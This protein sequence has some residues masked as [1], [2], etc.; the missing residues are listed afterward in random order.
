MRKVAISGNGVTYEGNR[1]C[2][3]TRTCTD[4]CIA[5]GVRFLEVGLDEES[6]KILAGCVWIFLDSIRFFSKQCRLSFSNEFVTDSVYALSGGS[7]PLGNRQ[8]QGLYYRIVRRDPVKSERER[9]TD[10]LEK[11]GCKFQYYWFDGPTE[12]I[13]GCAYGCDQ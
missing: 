13:C 2:E 6:Q 1:E 7:H 11:Q 5:H 10:E 4:I 9:G 12:R 8:R 3:R